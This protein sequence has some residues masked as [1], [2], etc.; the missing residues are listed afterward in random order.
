MRARIKFCGMSRPQD[1]IIASEL[2]ASYVGTVFAPGPRQVTGAVARSVF[3][4]VPGLGHVGVFGS[5]DPGEIAAL[6][7]EADLDVVQLHADPTPDDVRA[8]RD[9]FDGDIWAAIRVSG[10]S[11]PGAAAELFDSADGVLLDARGDQ[12]GG[13]GRAFAWREVAGEVA[14]LRRGGTLILAGGLTPQ[15]VA[16]AIST[17]APDVVDVSSGVESSPGIKCP[18]LMREFAHAVRSGEHS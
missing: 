11:L 5:N 16:E 13:T 15:N 7:A 18:R 4:S 10:E 12:L 14:R 2:G 6:A 3:D 17:L 9:V 8:V 1:A